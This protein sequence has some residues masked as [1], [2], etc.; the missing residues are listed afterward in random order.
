M[1]SIEKWNW[2]PNCRHFMKPEFLQKVYSKHKN[3]V[4]VRASSPET[5]EN[6]GAGMLHVTHYEKWIYYLTELQIDFWWNGSCFP[7][8][9]NIFCQGIC[10]CNL[11]RGYLALTPNLSLLLCSNQLF[12]SRIQRVIYMDKHLLWEAVLHQI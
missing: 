9:N 7:Q 11:V 12:S 4:K 5:V 2:R 6:D 10:F 1:S 8:C 3:C